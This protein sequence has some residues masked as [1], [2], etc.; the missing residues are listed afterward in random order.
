MLCANCGKIH[1][2]FLWI[3][4][5]HAFNSSQLHSRPSAVPIMSKWP[6]WFSGVVYW[7]VELFS[8]AI[9]A[10][11]CAWRTAAVWKTGSLGGP[12]TFHLWDIP[13]D[14]RHCAGRSRGTTQVSNTLRYCE[15]LPHQILPSYRGG[16][17][18]FML[19]QNKGVVLYFLMKIMHQETKLSNSRQINVWQLFWITKLGLSC[20]FIKIITRHN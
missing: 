5:S 19:V 16:F 12:N 2:I 18:I 13:L 7:S 9:S 15:R 20:I 17:F 8:G 1:H 14:R 10:R 4:T 11:S 3:L 6:R